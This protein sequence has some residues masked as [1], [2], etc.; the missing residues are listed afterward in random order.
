MTRS[1]TKIIVALMVAALI[2]W[3]GLM[4]G[5][6]GPYPSLEDAFG[7]I[8]ALA[9]D[10]QELVELEV[11][12]HSVE[13]R[14]IY[15][16]HVGIRDGEQRP[17]ALVTGNIHAG[18]VLSSRVA[19]AV[20]ERLAGDYGTD[21]WITS[22]LERS[23]FWVLPLLNPD[24]YRAS[25]SGKGKA[26]RK[27][28]HGV[29]LNRNFPLA[30]GAKSWHPLSGNRRPKSS[31]Y[32]GPGQLSEPETRA[33]AE[34]VKARHFYAATNGHTVAGKFLYPHGFTR[35]PSVH[36]A[37]FIRMGEAF[38][39]RQSMK[40]YK[41]Q[42]SCSWYPTLGDMD[43]FLYMEHGV[44]SVTI[45]H[46]TVWHN[47]KYVIAHPSLFWIANPHDAEEWVDNDRDAVL[48]ALEQAL[49]ITGG[50]PFDPQDCHPVEK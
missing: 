39:S 3:A 17:E 32:M 25:V 41:V 36:Q 26:L 35:R 8:K 31:Y 24:G 1:A 47:L 46:G 42:I 16:I 48:A 5:G 18:E 20:A 10:H 11:I 29:D 28:A 9:R 23:D 45:E 22:L 2:P 34:F 14:P 44:M 7:E 6:V 30:P 50:R 37:E 21:P 19:L 4:A 43:D 49:E 27:N 15:A 33:V 40:K 38:N 12:G 13:Q